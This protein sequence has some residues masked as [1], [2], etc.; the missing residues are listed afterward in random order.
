M[1]LGVCSLS[2]SMWI[3]CTLLKWLCECI[4][5]SSVSSLSVLL[6][7]LFVCL[8]MLKTKSKPAK[9]QRLNDYLGIMFA[10]PFIVDERFVI[11]ACTDY[12]ERDTI[13][14]NDMGIGCLSLSYCACVC[15]VTLLCIVC[16]SQSLALDFWRKSWNEPQGCLCLCLVHVCVCA[17][18]AVTF[19][20]CPFSPARGR[21]PSLTLVG[22]CHRMSCPPPPRCPQQPPS[23]GTAQTGTARTWKCRLHPGPSPCPSVSSPHHFHSKHRQLFPETNQ[24]QTFTRLQAVPELFHRSVL[25]LTGL[26][27]FQHQMLSSSRR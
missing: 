2:V 23:P 1:S 9:A 7:G 15:F 4:V 21:W 26:E 6:L 11:C 27:P 5:C 13:L 12:I 19:H 3:V 20:L 10:Y 24:G 16:V 8:L 17:C 18:S 25:H 14:I 22:H